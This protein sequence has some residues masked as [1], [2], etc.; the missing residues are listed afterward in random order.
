M[1]WEDLQGDLAEMYQDIQPDPWLIIEI[2]L[3][4]RKAWLHS[5]ARLGFNPGQRSAKARTFAPALPVRKRRRDTPDYS[6]DDFRAAAAK[7]RQLARD[8]ERGLDRAQILRAREQM[9]KP[10]WPPPKPGPFAH[11]PR[12]PAPPRPKRST[13]PRWHRPTPGLPQPEVPAWR[14][15][16]LRLSKAKLGT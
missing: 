7:R 2:A 8:R 5:K 3:Q 4:D 11:T 15:R 9:P 1:P 12:V 16:K 13:R 10:N 14:N 6:L